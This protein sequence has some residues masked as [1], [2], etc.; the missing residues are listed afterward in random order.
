MVWE[1]G[2]GDPAS[3]PIGQRIRTE[4][5]ANRTVNIGLL[6]QV[7]LAGMEAGIAETLG[8]DIC[9]YH[10]HLIY[11]A[12]IQNG[13]QKFRV[14]GGVPDQVKNSLF[15]NARC[16]EYQFE[17]YKIILDA[18]S[19][20]FYDITSK[21]K[22]SKH[23]GMIS[24]QL[25]IADLMFALKTKSAMVSVLGIPDTIRYEGKLSLDQISVLAGLMKTL[26]PIELA[27]PVPQWNVLSKDVDVFQEIISSD[28]FSCYSSSHAL[29]ELP[30]ENTQLVAKDIKVKG[31]ALVSK[32]SRYLDLQGMST[33]LISATT[34]I[35]DAFLGKVPGLVADVFGKKLQTLIDSNKRITIYDYGKSHK[36]LLF[37]HYSNLKSRRE[38]TSNNKV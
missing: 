12:M 17:Q 2:G 4:S 21:E 1:D 10:D 18:V 27:T 16:E 35:I 7:A 31:K 9:G 23:D 15:L 22:K 6:H 30:S 11:T 24:L 29:L 20:K 8:V 37:A 33:T 3:Y 36:E 19:D 28:L 38:D 25:F 13:V 14:I 32:F 34:S 5:M 26:E